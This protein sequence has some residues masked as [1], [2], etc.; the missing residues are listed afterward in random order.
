M[1]LTAGLLVMIASNPAS[2]QPNRVESPSSI[3]CVEHLEIPDYPVLA[4]SARTSGTL[5]VKVLLSDQATIQSIEIDLQEREAPGR[6]QFFKPSS[7]RAIKSSRFSKTCGGKTVTL[8]FHYE[9]SN[10]PVSFAFE[11]PNHFFMR[12]GPSVIQ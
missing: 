8:V 10:D 4:R 3:E 9:A 11:P 5:L 1:L 12:S 2:G 6:L 7:E